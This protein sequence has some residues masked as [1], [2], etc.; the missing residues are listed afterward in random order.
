MI[1]LVIT[2]S[3]TETV[4]GIF[5]ENQ[6]SLDKKL[7]FDLCPS[8]AS[9]MYTMFLF[10]VHVYF[11]AKLVTKIIIMLFLHTIFIFLVELYVVIIMVVYIIVFEP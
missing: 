11:W 6:T 7:T 9:G 10:Y 4:K 8:G 1:L 3:D 5:G 2:A